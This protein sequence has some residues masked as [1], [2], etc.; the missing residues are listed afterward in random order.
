M[1]LAEYFAGFSGYL[2]K[3]RWS[4]NYFLSLSKIDARRQQRFFAWSRDLIAYK[5]N[6]KPEWRLARTISFAWYLA[7][8]LSYLLTNALQD[9]IS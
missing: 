2:T 8:D 7:N 5:L 6:N 1:I 9:A 4:S 3:M